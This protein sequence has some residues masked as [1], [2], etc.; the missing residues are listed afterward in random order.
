[1]LVT[2]PRRNATIDV[3]VTTFHPIRWGANDFSSAERACQEW[4]DPANATKKAN[5][6]CDTLDQ[7]V[8]DAV[9]PAVRDDDTRSSNDHQ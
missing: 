1:M 7:A 5:H 9:V 8:I 4:L 6:I 3:N 2:C